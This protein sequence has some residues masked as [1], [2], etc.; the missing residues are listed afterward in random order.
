MKRRTVIVTLLLFFGAAPTWA[1]APAAN[2]ALQQ[3]L[4]QAVDRNDTP[5]VVGLVVDRQGVLFEG[6]AG[7]LDLARNVPLPVDAIFN[8]DRKS[9]V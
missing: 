5:G 3:V 4:S 1:A 2:A 7:K 8:I 9:V 6:A